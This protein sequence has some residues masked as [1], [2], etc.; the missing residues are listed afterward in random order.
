MQDLSS[1][2]SQLQALQR[3]RAVFLKSRNM[4]ANRLQAIVAGYSGYNSGMAESDRKKCF[5]EAAKLIAK[6]D[7]GQ[8][9]GELTP[10]IRTHLVAVNELEGQMGVLEKAM[11]TLAK[12]LPVAKWVEAPE[13]RGFGMLMLAIV[14]GET[15]DLSNYANPG[16]VW[17]RLGCAPF[18][19]QGETLMGGTWKRRAGGKGCH[20]LSSEEWESFGYSPRRRSIAFLIGDGLV[21]QNG[22]VS[23][24]MIETGG[25]GAGVAKNNGRGDGNLVEADRPIVSKPKNKKGRKGVATVATELSRADSSR[26]D[27]GADDD[28]CETESSVVGP[29]RRR[30]DET[31]ASFALKHPDAK[32]IQCHLH[33]M[34]CATKRLLRELWKEWRPE[35]EPDQWTKQAAGC[36][37]E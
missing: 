5:V 11:K 6:V 2:C 16:K 24:C 26:C 3:Q 31:K 27:G 37:L 7:K 29:Y 30:Y 20:K 1:V 34:L 32:P 17:R 35:M 10:L 9:A 25:G 13:Q 23:V 19:S 14:I 12:Q 18:T 33:G 4:V 22:N 36:F 21:K 8:D 28:G 15:G